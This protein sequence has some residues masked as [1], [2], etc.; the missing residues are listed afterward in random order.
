MLE[1]VVVAAGPG[2]A[3]PL[4]R[5]AS[6]AVPGATVRLLRHD[7]GPLAHLLD[8]VL[9]ARPL[10]DLLVLAGAT[11]LARPDGI[12]AIVDVLRTDRTL[13]AVAIDAELGTEPDDL[14]EA[15]AGFRAGPLCQAG[16]FA[17]DHVD[18]LHVRLRRV[19]FPTAVLPA[20]AILGRRHPIR[21][22]VPA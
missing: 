4:P 16:G 22:R 6:V 1:T 17:G 8:E 13:A 15:G 3:E 14:L 10:V 2:E 11:A 19:G 9:F 20:S 7:G 12:R 21:E 18:P 5:L